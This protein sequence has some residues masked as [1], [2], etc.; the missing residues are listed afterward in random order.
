MKSCLQAA[1][2]LTVAFGNLIVVIEA[3]A[4]LFT[5]QALEFFFFAGMLGVVTLLFMVMSCLYKYVEPQSTVLQSATEQ[6]NGTTGI[7][8]FMEDPTTI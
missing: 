6:S 5:N 8:R 7:L 3:E 4:R 1:W 2:L